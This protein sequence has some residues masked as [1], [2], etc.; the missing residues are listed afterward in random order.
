MEDPKATIHLECRGQHDLRSKRQ[1]ADCGGRGDGT[2]VNNTAHGHATRGVLQEAAIPP[3][4]FDSRA[5]PGPS[6]ALMPPH[7]S[8]RIPAIASDWRWRTLRCA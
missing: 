8:C 4:R 6:E 1:R 5:G 2:V 3:P 7:V